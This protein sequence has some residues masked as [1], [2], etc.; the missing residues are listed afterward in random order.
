M[1]V[2][3]GAAAPSR[4]GVLSLSSRP[5]LALK[6]ALVLAA[7]LAALVLVPSGAASAAA[8]WQGF[9]AG[10]WP[11]PE[12]RPYA[13]GSPFNQ[14]VG[15][16]PVHPDSAALVAGALQWG[17]PA[18]LTAGTAET[19]SDFGHPVYFSQPGDPLYTL[20]PTEHWGRNTIAGTRIRIPAGARPA[21]GSDGH[22][23]VVTP[24]GWEYDFWR[25]QAPPP[26]GGTLTFAWG[27]RVRI[28]GDGLG[29]SATAAHFGALAGVIRPEELAAG[30]IDHALFIVLR[31]TAS[32]TSFG[33]G[34]RKRQ[35]WLGS[36]IY[37]AAAGASTCDEGNSGLPPL[38]AR[39]ALAMSSSQIAGLGLPRWKRAILTALARYGGYVGDT[40]GPGFALMMQSSSTYTSLGA[41]DRLAQVARGAGIPERQG[42]YTFPLAAGVDWQRYL[43]VVVPPARL[44]AKRMRHA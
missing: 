23:T 34:A 8:G 35:S 16:A 21:G 41:P 2:R 33:F 4:S 43:R 17:P 38:G 20:R 30:R 42:R 13:A 32:G 40:G 9:G 37:P 15:N 26:G 27:G 7:V 25:A 1:T 39:F 14:Q 29:G 5:A 44:R 12:W 6:A 24:D 10:K 11:G 18:S 3:A 28:T 31:C 22:M 19:S 36:Y